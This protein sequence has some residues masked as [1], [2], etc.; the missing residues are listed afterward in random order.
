MQIAHSSQ[1]ELLEL[2][3]EGILDN[4]SSVH[5]RNCID[6]YVRDG[7]HRI[8]V[9]MQGV[10]YISSAGISALLAAKDQLGQL[11]GFFGIS[12]PTPEV[13]RVLAQVRLLKVLV[14]DPEQARAGSPIGNRTR[15]LEAHIAATPLLEL[16]TYSLDEGASLRCHI[17]GDP[18][19]IFDSTFSDQNC[20]SIGFS[21]KSLAVGVGAL[22][23]DFA[24]VR[25]R[26]R[27]FLAVAGAVAQSAQSQRELPDF[28]LSQ[29]EFTPRTQ[30][31]YGLQCD[32]EFSHLIRFRP[33]SSTVRVPLSEVVSECLRQAG[34]P[35]AG[36]VMLAESAGLLGAHLRQSPAADAASPSQRFEFPEIREWISFSPERVYSRNLVLIV[37]VAQATATAPSSP[38]MDALL[39]PIDANG[40][41]CGHLH[42]AV[43]PYRP[44]KKRTLDLQ[45]SVRELFNS[46]TIQDVLHLLRDDRSIIGTGESELLD[47]A[48]WI[49]PITNIATGERNG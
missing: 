45:D 27:E 7:W 8:L 14:S 30:V 42:A 35:S 39:R 4:E 32:G 2:K 1:G 20:R 33:V 46:G 23:P 5:F 13:E 38:S 24:A 41:L 36:I 21:D 26:F 40:T 28:S 12:A 11:K 22:G 25:P 16:Q 15:S 17:V 34:C 49:S 31:L 48:C 18:Q 43:F 37:G 10:S 44:L 29:G 9:D 19:P 47:G 6:D 3:I